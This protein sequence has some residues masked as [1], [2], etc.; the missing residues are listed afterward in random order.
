[1]KHEMTSLNLFHPRETILLVKMI[2][3][4]MDRLDDAIKRL[5]KMCQSYIVISLCTLLTSYYFTQ[6]LEA[7]RTFS[8]GI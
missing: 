3:L 2:S 1:M 8:H 4:K 7:T 5:I 6:F